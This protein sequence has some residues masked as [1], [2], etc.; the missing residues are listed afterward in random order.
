MRIILMHFNKVG[1]R[2]RG[3]SL[4]LFQKNE[5][6]LAQQITTRSPDR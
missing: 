4:D 1:G 6:I 5:E 3:S 2:S